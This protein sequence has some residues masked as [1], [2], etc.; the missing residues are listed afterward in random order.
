MTSMKDS[1]LERLGKN[2]IES[3]NNNA[4]KIE[5]KRNDGSYVVEINFFVGKSK[6]ILDKIDSQALRFHRGGVGFYHQL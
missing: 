3:L 5:R 6:D 4:I 2:L 1:N